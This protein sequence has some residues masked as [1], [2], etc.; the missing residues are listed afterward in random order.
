MATDPR[1]SQPAIRRAKADSYARRLQA[2]LNRI[3]DALMQ[4]RDSFAVRLS[5]ERRRFA[6]PTTTPVEPQL[7]DENSRFAEFPTQAPASFESDADLEALLKVWPRLSRSVKSAILAV[8][9]T[10]SNS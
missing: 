1:S 7:V 10:Q 3:K 6:P 9:S 4:P 2:E 5:A 8:V